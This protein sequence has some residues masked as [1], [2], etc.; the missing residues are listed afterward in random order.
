MSLSADFTPWTSLLG[1]ALI[2]LSA[3]LFMLLNGRIAG[4]S[5][6]LG[7]LLSRR[8]DGRGE[9]LVF[10]AG[11]IASPLIW[12]LGAPLPQPSFQVGGVALVLAGVLVGI[13]TRYGAGCTSGHGVCGLSR[14][15]VRSLVAVGCFMGSGFAGVY[16]LRHVV[17]A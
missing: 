1:G 2:G 10:V 14:L 5:G 12:L 3:G 6:L 13:G 7:S 15:S 4:I 16:V 17:G 8:S 9:A 11:L